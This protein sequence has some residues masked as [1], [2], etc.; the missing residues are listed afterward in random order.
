MLNFADFRVSARLKV[1]VH[2]L[3]ELG[4]ILDAILNRACMDEVEMVDGP[5]PFFLEIVD[6]ELDVCIDPRDSI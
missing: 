4:V 5:G 6:F 3:D 2:L 1:Y